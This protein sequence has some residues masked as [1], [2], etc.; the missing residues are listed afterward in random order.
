MIVRW[1]KSQDVSEIV[2]ECIVLAEKDM[3]SPPNQVEPLNLMSM[4]SISEQ[5]INTRTIPLPDNFISIRR[6]RITEDTGLSSVSVS[7]QYEHDELV[8]VAPNQLKIDKAEGRPTRYTVRAGMIEFNRVPDTDYTLEL[9]YFGEFTPLSNE[10]PV[11]DVLLK[12][13]KLYL[14]GALYHA[15]NFR[16]EN[17]RS[18]IY[19][20]QFLA[21]ISAANRTDKRGRF[22]VG[23]QWTSPRRTP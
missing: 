2:D 4:E 14:Y 5:V 12:F 21:A 9:T 7:N 18:Q 1:S 13:P 19:S 15:M 11:N 22:N 20:S 8:F 3:L 17:D 6:A 23:K 10:E 16:E